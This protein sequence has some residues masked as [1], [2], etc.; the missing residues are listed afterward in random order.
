MPLH[1]Q[2]A[3]RLPTDGRNGTLYIGATANPAARAWQ[4]RDPPS[5]RCNDRHAAA[6]L[7]RQEMHDTMQTPSIRGQRPG[8]WHPARKRRPGGRTGPSPDA[9]SPVQARIAGDR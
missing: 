5:P 9:A 4:H 3:N 8:T 1:R 7:A 2:P 6:R